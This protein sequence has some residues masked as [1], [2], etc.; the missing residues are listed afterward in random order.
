[1]PARRSIVGIAAFVPSVAF[2]EQRPTVPHARIHIEEGLKNTENA[3]R[4]QG[5]F[6]LRWAELRSSDSE[7]AASEMRH[8]LPDL[9]Q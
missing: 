5:R 3:N 7:V 6:S 2:A 4:P 1:M 9:T 8:E